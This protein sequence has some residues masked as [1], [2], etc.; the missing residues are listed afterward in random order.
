MG[1]RKLGDVF[2]AIADPTRRQILHILVLSKAL[3]MQ[4]IY[5]QF[6]SSRQAVTKHIQVL[7]QAGLVDIILTGRERTCYP[8]AAR[9]SEV[10]Q[11]VKDYQ[12]F[13]D[14]KFIS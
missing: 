8:R 7:N 6:N 9:L 5:I 4:E 1:K 10:Y 13:W 14:Q 12:K 3:T 11:W 2:K